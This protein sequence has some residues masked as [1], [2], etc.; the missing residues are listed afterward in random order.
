[1]ASASVPKEIWR[2][3]LCVYGTKMRRMGCG[4]E[5]DWDAIEIIHHLTNKTKNYRIKNIW[6]N[7][8]CC[9]FGA[10]I[11]LKFLFWLLYDFWGQCGWNQFCAVIWTHES[12]SSSPTIESKSLQIS[13]P[14]HSNYR[15]EKTT[16]KKQKPHK[17][18]EEEF[19]WLNRRRVKMWV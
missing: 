1:M 6:W 9:S 17:I 13:P 10:V 5:R 18:E 2:G 16:T 11:I 19:I 8:F 7:I 3:H 15:G 14:P 12:L 4:A